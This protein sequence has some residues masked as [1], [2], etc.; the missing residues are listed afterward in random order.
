[1][2][3]DPAAGCRHARHARPPTGV[4]LVHY[5]IVLGAI[6][7]FVESLLPARLGAH[8]KA[9][10]GRVL[11]V[12]KAVAGQCY[13]RRDEAAADAAAAAAKDGVAATK[14]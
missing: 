4:E 8:E 3:G 13:A 5:D 1:M 10:W 11:G 12:V 14:G 7:V 6:T 9:A 2:W